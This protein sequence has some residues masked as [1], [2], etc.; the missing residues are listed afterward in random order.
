MQQ[1]KPGRIRNVNVKQF[2][3]VF[4]GKYHDQKLCSIHDLYAIFLWHEQRKLRIR[5]FEKKKKKSTAISHHF[6][7]Y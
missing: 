6:F 7:G 5:K 4:V 1:I 3:I 2:G